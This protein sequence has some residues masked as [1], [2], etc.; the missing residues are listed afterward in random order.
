MKRQVGCQRPLVPGRQDLGQI[1][2]RSELA[3]Q[4]LGVL[5]RL[6]KTRL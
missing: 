6:G 2:V 4:I 5:R 1:L 3:M